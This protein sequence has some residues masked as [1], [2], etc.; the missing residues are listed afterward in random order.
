MKR[1]VL[2][3]L[4]LG[5]L[6]TACQSPATQTPAAIA[7]I[8][9]APVEISVSAAASLTEAFGE[10]GPLFETL[11]PEVKVIFNFAGSQALAEQINNGAPV[12]VFASASKKTMQSVV[13]AN[14][15]ASDAVQQFVSN[16]L[17]VITPAS[18]PAGINQLQDL[19]KAGIKLVLAAKEV[20]VGQYS[21]D[22]LAKAAGTS[23]FP[24]T[25]SEDV[26][27]NVVSYEDNVKA[28]LTKVSLGE[29]DAGIVYTTD[30]ASAETGAIQ[31]ITIPDEFNIPASYFIAT[32]SNSSHA[33]EAKLFIDY[34]LSAAGQAILSKYGFIPVQ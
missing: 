29:A 1:L 14:N 10:M 8:P 27:K 18:N 25:F 17:V 24:S 4:V 31:T 15:I 2:C 16:K 30:A 12:D 32:V 21:L 22:F 33:A 20:P 23:D 19:T 3:I 7:T 26:L 6:L 34:V 28:V 13:D 9:P 5:L 11:H